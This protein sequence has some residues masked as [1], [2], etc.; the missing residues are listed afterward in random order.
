MTNGRNVRS[1]CSVAAKWALPEPHRGSA[2]DWLD[3]YSKGEVVLIAP[4]VLLAELASLLAKRHRQKEISAAQAHYAYTLM[5]IYGPQFFETRQ[6]FRRALALSLEYQLSL[7]D[8]VYLALA[9]EFECPVL[10]ADVRLFRGTTGRH[11]SVQL[12]H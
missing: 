1:A 8:C 9:E 6:R 2:L 5:E 3:R 7:W 10:T 4:D 11:P 12:V